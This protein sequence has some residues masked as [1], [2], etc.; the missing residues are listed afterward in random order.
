[1]SIAVVGT[2]QTYLALAPNAIPGTVLGAL[3]PILSDGPETP[4]PAKAG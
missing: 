2:G 4:A 3:E 1:M